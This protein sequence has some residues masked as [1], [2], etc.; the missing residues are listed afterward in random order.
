MSRVK[1]LT[2]VF[3]CG[4]LILAGLLIWQGPSYYAD[5]FPKKASTPTRRFASTR[6]ATSGRSTTRI[7]KQIETPPGQTLLRELPRQAFFITAAQDFGLAVCDRSVDFS[8]TGDELKLSCKTEYLFPTT[9]R[10]TFSDAGGAQS[11]VVD[12]PVLLLAQN[13]P[14][15]AKIAASV[16]PMCDAEFAL[17]LKSAGHESHAAKLNVSQPPA[18]EIEDLL[19]LV[20]PQHAFLAAHRLHEATAE[21]GESPERLAGLVRAYAQLG[22]STRHL[23]SA[24]G[25]AFFARALVYAERLVR[26][27]PQLPLSHAARGYAYALLGEPLDAQRSF[28]KARALAGGGN[29][30]PAWAELADH[31]SR[32]RTRELFNRIDESDA[33]PLASYFTLLTVEHSG[34]QSLTLNT[35]KLTLQHNPDSWRAIQIATDNAGFSVEREANQHSIT[36]W[37]VSLSRLASNDNIPDAIRNAASEAARQKFAPDA[38]AALFAKMDAQPPQPG[39]LLPWSVYASICRDQL[40]LSAFRRFYFMRSEGAYSR[41]PSEELKSWWPVLKDHRFASAIAGFDRTKTIGTRADRDRLAYVTS[42]DLM[43]RMKWICAELKPS[44]PATTRP[45]LENWEF[46]SDDTVYDLT[47]RLWMHHGRL[48]DAERALGVIN[49]T[50]VVDALE[51]MCPNHP[52]ALAEIIISRWP[53]VRPRAAEIDRNYG[54]NPQ[55]AYPLARAYHFDKRYADA[56]RLLRQAIKISPDAQFYLELAEVYNDQGD[57]DKMLAAFDKYMESNDEYFIDRGRK[58]ESLAYQLMRRGESEKALKYAKLSADIGSAWGMNVHAWC[59]TELGRFQEAEAI[60]KDCQ[61]SYPEG[62]AWHNW[63]QITGKGDLA[64]ARA[65]SQAWLANPKCGKDPRLV[66]Q[67]AAALQIDG[68]IDRARA[69][70]EKQFVGRHDPFYALQLAMI[71]LETGKSQAATDWLDQLPPLNPENKGGFPNGFPKLKPG[72]GRVYVENTAPRVRAYQ[73]VIDQVR[74][75]MEAPT[76][77]LPRD[78]DAKLVLEGPAISRGDGAYFLGRVCELRGKKLDAAWW[79]RKSLESKDWTFT[80]RPFAAAGLRRSGEEFYK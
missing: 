16:E 64:A 66:E 2:G 56:E 5:V 43:G 63:C 1:V 49:D 34:L 4:L 51:V 72:V 75:C 42:D 71:D 55:V 80:S 57:E 50:K 14:D 73:F 58:L 38:L 17:L 44:K 18:P 35:V 46:T 29:A 77:V 33:A 59:L 76:A 52:S 3:L 6:R 45:W 47:H 21:T 19:S 54:D 67:V 8:G 40:F 20:D 69:I 30:L 25:S 53:E 26:L 61:E 23:Y 10:V 11:K 15:Y 7:T 70:W 31:L 41:D 13:Y 36:A 12:V 37:L 24:H 65:M 48:F 68:Q 79:Y 60:E 32:F 22:E 9:Q 39:Q 62:F 28:D 78:G 74:K 27:N